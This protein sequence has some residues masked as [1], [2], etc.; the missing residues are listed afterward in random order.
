MA[1]EV[2]NHALVAWVEEMAALCQPEAISWC[3]GSKEEYDRLMAE[4]V[5]SGMAT[6]LRRP[7]S[8]LF[9]SDPSDVAR[10]EDRT[11]IATPTPEEA[12]PTNNWVEADDAQDDHAR[13][14]PR[15]H[16]RPHDVRHPLLHGA[17]SARPCQTVFGLTDSPYVV[18]NMH[19]MTRVGDTR[20]AELGAD[21]DFHPLPAL[22]GRAAGARPAGR[23]V[24]MRADGTEV[25]RPLPRREPD[26]VLWLRLRR[27]R[28]AGQE[29]PSACASPR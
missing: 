19:I 15:L 20:A 9:R 7:N 2:K 14:L 24:A 1:T 6:P 10:V 12:G 8:F 5:A 26:L 28:P 11:Y 25:H 23:R 18:C 4:M 22:R 13:A 27:Q 16:A 3:D 21:G 17:D 29:V